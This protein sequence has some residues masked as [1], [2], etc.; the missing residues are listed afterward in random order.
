MTEPGPHSAPP[1]P[2]VGPRALRVGE[3]IFGRDSIAQ[4]L[5]DLLIAERIVLLYSPSGAG[6]TSLIQ[7]GLIPPLEKDGFVV[8]P[9]LRVGLSPDVSVVGEARW[10]RYVLSVVRSLDTGA[11]KAVNAEPLITPETTLGAYLDARRQKRQAKR[12][13]SASAMAPA[14][15]EAGVDS[16]ILI[17]DQFEEILTVDYTD[18]DAKEKFF[19]QLGQT[20]RD[21]HRWALFAMREEYLGALESYQRCIPGWLATRVRLDLLGHADAKSAIIGLASTVE[22]EFTDPAATK[23]VTDLSTVTTQSPTG[24]PIEQVGPYVEPVYLQVVCQ[25]LWDRWAAKSGNRKQILAED[26]D[27][28]TDID[29]ALGDYYDD[30]VHAVTQE[31]AKKTGDGAVGTAASTPDRVAHDTSHGAESKALQRIEWSIRQWIEDRLITPDGFRGQVILGKTTTRELDADTIDLLVSAF[32]VRREKRLNAVWL[33]LAH[34]RLIDPVLQRNERW[35]RQHSSPVRHQAELWVSDGRPRVSLLQGEALRDAQ[36]WAAA[37]PQEVN[38]ATR[39]FIAL[40]RSLRKRNRNIMIGGVAMALLVGMGAV[41]LAQRGVIRV[42]RAQMQIAEVAR[43]AADSAR[44]LAETRLAELQKARVLLGSARDSLATTQAV[45]VKQFAVDSPLST[46]PTTG[47]PLS[48][49]NIQQRLQAIAQLERSRPDVPSTALDEVTVRYFAR[50]VDQHKVQDALR[51]LGFKLERSS[52]RLESSTNA[53]SFGHD[54]GEQAKL[55][56]Y[57][58][59]RAGIDIKRFAPYQGEGGRAR[60][61]TIYG[62]SDLE[63]TR[64]MTVEQVQ[65]YRSPP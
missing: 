12:E 52:G 57:T 2:Y 31:R 15:G 5:V 48:A 28:T 45:L 62:V 53:I 14:E 46:Q 16:E 9:P 37:N 4:N 26:I 30:K 10:N 41:V 20:L 25:R 38:E 56:A 50:D 36:Q 33:E 55:I 7:A 22:V 17:F 8:T 3:P 47:A 24:E 61:V 54:V 19:Q 6:K 58:L 35:F 42:A 39:D 40:S 43:A 13:A 27:A 11:A 29:T 63:S 49:P 60:V 51:G 23:L 34:D 44:Q 65:A 18:R 32:L 1:N 59:I 64:P 21:P